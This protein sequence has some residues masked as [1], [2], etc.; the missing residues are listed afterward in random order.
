MCANTFWENKTLRAVLGD[1]NEGSKTSLRL[2]LA[3]ILFDKDLYKPHLSKYF[4]LT[5]K[6]KNQRIVYLSVLQKFLLKQGDP[7]PQMLSTNIS[8][9]E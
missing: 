6:C 2:L 8:S 4:G 7:I 1:S 9:F 5:D 3:E